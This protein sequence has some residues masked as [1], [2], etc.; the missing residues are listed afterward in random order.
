MNAQEARNL[1]NERNSN[2]GLAY[3][4]DIAIKKAIEKGEN[5]VKIDTIMQNTKANQNA[6]AEYLIENGFTFIKIERRKDEGLSSYLGEGCYNLTVSFS[7]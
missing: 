7:F 6:I 5:R 4:F 1:L 3:H 2:M